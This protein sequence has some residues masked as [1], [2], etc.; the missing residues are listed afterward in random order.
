MP[1]LYE[2]AVNLLIVSDN[3]SEYSVILGPKLLG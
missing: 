3:D 1:R 2:R